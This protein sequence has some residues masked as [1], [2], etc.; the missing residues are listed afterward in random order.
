MGA[1]VGPVGDEYWRF[2]AAPFV[3]DDLGYLFASG[4]PWRSS[5]PRSNDASG[6]CPRRCWWSPAAPLGMLFAVGLE[7]A[8][9]DGVPVAAGGNGIALGVLGAWLV[10]RDADRRRD[11]TEEY[12]QVA[13]AVCAAVLLLLPLVED[14]ANP[15][16]GLGGALVGLACGLGAALGRGR[17]AIR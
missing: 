3:Y 15:W 7:N 14:L 11:P 6:P 16:A 1:I 10:M 2:S 8:V 5:C 13:V 17:P 4:W 12:D 9:G